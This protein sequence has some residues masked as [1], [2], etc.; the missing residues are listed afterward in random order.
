MR[1]PLMQLTPIDVLVIALYFA[2]NIAVALYLRRR[3]Y[4]PQHGAEGMEGT[5]VTHRGR[6][7]DFT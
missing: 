5:P 7:H 4:L 6:N 2:F 1:G 3:D